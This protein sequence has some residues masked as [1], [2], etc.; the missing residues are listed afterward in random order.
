M[1]GSITDP[2]ICPSAHLLLGLLVDCKSVCAIIIEAPTPEVRETYQGQ[3][4][5][6]EVVLIN[7]MIQWI[8]LFRLKKKKMY[9]GVIIGKTLLEKGLPSQ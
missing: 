8:Y 4:S 6:S 2:P 9:T 1:Q 7:N 5:H 3:M